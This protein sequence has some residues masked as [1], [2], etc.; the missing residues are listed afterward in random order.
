MGVAAGE[1]RNPSSL[2]GFIV[3]P[4]VFVGT[5]QVPGQREFGMSAVSPQHVEEK[6]RIVLHVLMLEL[7]LNT[8]MPSIRV[9][10]AGEPVGISHKGEPAL[11][12]KFGQKQ[13]VSVFRFRNA[14]WV[15]GISSKRSLVCSVQFVSSDKQSSFMKAIES[16]GGGIH[17][18]CGVFGDHDKVES[19]G[20]FEVPPG[21]QCCVHPATCGRE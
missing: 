10:P 3:L 16:Q 5:R 14:S 12:L 18:V 15:P 8:S 17:D 13:G 11:F 21:W 7:R 4:Q 20:A 6:Q 19:F 9:I 2:R 1:K